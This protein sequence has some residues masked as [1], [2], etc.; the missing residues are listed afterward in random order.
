MMINIQIDT[1]MNTHTNTSVHTPDFTIL[2][3]YSVEYERWLIIR[4]VLLT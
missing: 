4:L 3:A 2:P 1:H